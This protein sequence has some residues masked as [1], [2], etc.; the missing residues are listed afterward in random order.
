MKDK[1]V[2]KLKS[3]DFIMV[4]INGMIVNDI[5][6]NVKTRNVKFKMLLTIEST[7]KNKI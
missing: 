6:I 3:S 1:K 4:N 2:L 7:E 5:K